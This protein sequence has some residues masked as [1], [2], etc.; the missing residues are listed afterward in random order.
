MARANSRPVM[1]LVGA[2]MGLIFGGQGVA[3]GSAGMDPTKPPSWSG[4]P[5]SEKGSDTEVSL[6]LQSIL[7]G[8]GR[9][10]ALINGRAYRVGE[11]VGSLTVQNIYRDRVVLRR[12][13]RTRVLR[14]TTSSGMTKTPSP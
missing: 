7:V 2:S 14:L 4:E 11:M 10:V 13:E 5:A 12:E 1:V 8:K 3:G 6:N 9:R